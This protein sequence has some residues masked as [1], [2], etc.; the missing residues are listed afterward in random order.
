MQ[1][2]EP[3]MT[4]ARMTS[5]AAF[6]EG[7][8]QDACDDAC[9]ICLENF[10]ENDPATITNCK[11]EYHLQC[12]LE[13]SQ[14]SKECPMC[15]QPLSLKDP[16]SQAL[17]AASE[18]ERLMRRQ[19]ASPFYQ[20]SPLDDS[21]FH[22]FASSYGDDSDLED[23]IMQHLAAAAMGRAQQFARRGEPLRFRPSSGQGH[24][25]FMIVP[26][27]S[28]SLPS[29]FPSSLPS[30]GGS[31]SPTTPPDVI[32]VGS[33]PEQ[34]PAGQSTP[35]YG[36]TASEPVR[37]SRNVESSSVESYSLRQ[38]ALLEPVDESQQ[39]TS[40]SELQSF[41]ESFKSRIAAA[42]SRYKES[43]T[44]TTR[45]FRERLRARNG[46]M[47]DLGARAREV[48]AG[49]VRAL[50][51]ISIES[52]DKNRDNINGSNS[53]SGVDTQVGT[54]LNNSGPSRLSDGSESQECSSSS[55]GANL[56][57]GSV[58]ASSSRVAPQP[59]G[60]EAS[61]SVGNTAGKAQGSEEASNH[62]HD[63]QQ[64][65]AASPLPV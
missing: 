29:H 64:R 3:E 32:S 58:S 49:V 6:V 13:W 38:R 48:S 9:S 20:R 44:K 46:A 14:R 60:V 5:A 10:C 25:H 47:A 50:E 40:S 31:V 24:P 28:T 56:H 37:V 45:G 35:M 53:T 33:S 1:V 39:G 16:D 7:G 36:R 8:V 41:S 26:A 4:E 52:A 18:Q 54:T 11:H 63:L 55:Q 21:E 12:I 57:A 59:N 17:L 23:R 61:N 19:R 51:R 2:A 15:W 62:G 30:T 27:H 65:V 43:L 42:S 34:T 22:R